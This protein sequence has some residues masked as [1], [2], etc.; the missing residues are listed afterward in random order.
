MARPFELLCQPVRAFFTRQFRDA[1]HL[2]QAQAGDVVVVMAAGEQ[3]AVRMANNAPKRDGYCAVLSPCWMRYLMRGET[4]GCAGRSG[5]WTGA[6]PP[7]AA[8][9]AGF[10]MRRSR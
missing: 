3:G 7:G 9:R 2:Q 8:L 6:K 4:A 10:R 1:V 5:R